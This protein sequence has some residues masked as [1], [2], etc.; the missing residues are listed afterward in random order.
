MYYCSAT[1]TDEIK[2]QL[3]GVLTKKHHILFT[4]LNHPND[5]LGYSYVSLYQANG[6][7]LVNIA[8]LLTLWL[9]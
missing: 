5:V 7:V 2:I 1:F 3:P 4:I 9:E 6:F 8:L